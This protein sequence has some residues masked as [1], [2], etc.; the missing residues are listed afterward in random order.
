MEQAEL[1][2]EAVSVAD[3]LARLQ[4]SVAEACVDPAQRRLLQVAL[5]GLNGQ[6]QRSIA[7]LGWV[8]C[9][10]LPLQV[11][12]AVRGDCAPALPLAA[13][14]S[15]IFLGLDIFDDLAD[16]DEPERWRGYSPGQI[17]L[18][19]ALT[20]NVLPAWLLARLP[21][22]PERLLLMQRTLA[23]GYLRMAAGQQSDLAMTGSAA[24]QATEVEASVLG[25][26][27]EQFATYAALGAQLAG[28][29]PARVALFASVGRGL[30]IAGQLASDCFELFEAGF[31]R[32]LAAGTRTLPIAWYLQ[33]LD[34]P[35]R[36]DFLQ[37][38]DNARSDRQAQL[39]VAD[40]LRAQGALRY[41]VFIAEL[42]RQRALRALTEAAPREPAGSRLRAMLESVMAG[43][44]GQQRE[45]R[46]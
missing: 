9:V 13:L 8:H 1:R 17:T 12:A 46:G 36:E 45:E 24:P 26:A 42:H 31:S 33:R 30:G 25:K 15:S 39:K 11:H 3:V 22:S 6:F 4:A 20:A 27:G 41:T 40:V 5:S 18:A 43:A 32:D 7:E 28:A 23:D 44:G 37:L 29:E 38:L 16:G 10:E 21:V 2:P 34:G 14:C 35:A 19:A